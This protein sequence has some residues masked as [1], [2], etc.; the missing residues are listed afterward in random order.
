MISP[1][2]ADP[3]IPVPDE[4]AQEDIL[5][6][7]RTG[8]GRVLLLAVLALASIS[9]SAAGVPR[10]RFTKP[11]TLESANLR[12][13]LMPDATE[14]PLPAL[15]AYTYE[16]SATGERLDLYD[17]AD[18]WRRSEHLAE[19]RDEFGTRMRIMKPT[20]ILPDG[21]SRAHVSREEYAQVTSK[22]R[23][24]EWTP[25]SL[26]QW[27]SAVTGL[28]FMGRADPLRHPQRMRSL[29][30]LRLENQ[31]DVTL[32]YF[33]KFRRFDEWFVLT[34]E[35]APGVDPKKA[36][37]AVQQ[38]LLG[39]MAIN[40]T[41]SGA[42]DDDPSSRFRLRTGTAARSATAELRGS[43]A[44][45]LEN[46]R[47][48]NNWWYVET[49]FYVIMSNLGSKHSPMI[50]RF[51]K[52]MPHMRRA[53]LSLIPPRRPIN[54]VSVIRVFA[55]AEEYAAYVPEEMRWSAGLW[56]AGQRELVISPIDEG[57]KRDQ[58]KAVHDVLYHEAFHQYLFYAL[59]QAPV[60]MWFNEGHA[61][62]F[63]GVKMQG[64]SIQIIE[65]E[66]YADRL[67]VMLKSGTVDLEELV[68]LSPVEFYG[69]DHQTREVRYTASWGLVYYLRKGTAVV[70]RSP[71]VGILD[72]YVDALWETKNESEA[73]ERAFRG[74]DFRQLESDFGT[75]WNTPDLRSKAQRIR[76]LGRK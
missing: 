21:F 35:L 30:W 49:P 26:A 27:F 15:K 71:Y 47:N 36:H 53:Y 42:G 39:T 67:V 55:T 38:Q 56:H 37:L 54:A 22:A 69:N 57:K 63:E 70:K 65:A 43:R 48:L 50:K 34:F 4:V 7:S 61:T 2:A 17:P 64:S 72:R 52:D 18:L 12:I 20:M 3:G 51:Q 9:A 45:V 76:I 62:L 32:A 60:S 33:L 1:T 11:V 14:V 74:V 24:V 19:W 41:G 13:R 5:T 6:E 44:Q 23:E 28:P 8:R 29:D 31:G 68:H 75:F 59:D 25:L 10:L 58:R 40:L 73:T 16:N 46:I 66:A